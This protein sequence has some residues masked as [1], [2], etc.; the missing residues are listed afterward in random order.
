[1]E[2]INWLFHCKNP[3][4]MVINDLNLEGV[5]TLPPKYDPPLIIYTDRVVTLPITSQCFK[6]VPWRYAQV[7][8]FGGIVYI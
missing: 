1:M 6:P 4:S 5:T 7:F 2:R 3:Y 8:Q